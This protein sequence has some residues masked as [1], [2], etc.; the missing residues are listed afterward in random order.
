MQIKK[1]P[2]II[3]RL[4]EVAPPLKEF[5][6]TLESCP[7]D[8]LII[9]IREFGSLP[10][11]RP[12]G[13]LCAWIP[14]LNRFDLI[15]EEFVTKY[16]LNTDFPRPVEI[17]KEDE[18]VLVNVLQFSSFLLEKCSNRGIYASIKHLSHLI[19]ATSPSIVAAALRVSVQLAHRFA[20]S[21][22]GK[23][24]VTALDPEKIF[25][26]ATLLP[27][28]HWE[29][30][31]KRDIAYVDYI[32]KNSEH[33]WD[34]DEWLTFSIQY[35]VRSGENKGK[36]GSPNAN[37]SGSGVTGSAN[38]A[39]HSRATNSSFQ[40][41]TPTRSLSHRQPDALGLSSSASPSLVPVS[42]PSQTSSAG[43]ASA[44]MP[45]SSEATEGLATLH[46][47]AE[48]IRNLSFVQLL[49]KLY[50]ALPQES[51]F[52]A[53]CKA[54][55]AKAC[56]NPM[57]AESIELRRE[58]CKIQFSA[59]SF[60]CCT[61]SEATVDSRIITKAPNLIRQIASIISPENSS[62]VDTEFS[63]LALEALEFVCHQ[64]ARRSD[65]LAALS[66]N[67]SH[68]VLMTVVRNIIRDL[69]N[70]EQHTF[71][72]EFACR[73]F[74]L[75]LQLAFTQS[76][77]AILVTTGLVQL[78]LEV[79]V[80]QTPYVRTLGAAMELLDQV[81][82]DISS[83]FSTFSQSGGI[84]ILIEVIKREISCD[85]SPDRPKEKIPDYCT[86]DYTLSFYRSQWVRS[87]FVV[88]SN[89]LVH[90]RTSENIHNLVDSP[91]LEASK[92]VI[93]NPTI[94]G[95]RI[96]SLNLQ[97][98]SSML[99]NE[100]SSFG[101]M[102]EAK[103]VDSVLNQVPILLEKSF[104]YFSPIAKLIGALSHNENGIKIIQERNMIAKFMESLSNSLTTN[105]TLPLLGAVFEGLTSDHPELRKQ[106]IS[107]SKVLLRDLPKLLEPVSDPSKF[108]LE[109]E[110]SNVTNH[111]SQ[112]EAESHNSMGDS[113]ADIDIDIDAN[114][115]AEQPT[116]T[117][118]SI[119]PETP[120]VVVIVG[121][122]ASFFDGL[123]KNH[124]TRVQFIKQNGVTDLLKIF[125]IPNLPYDFA[126]SSVGYT[127]GRI[128]RALF[129]L[130]I[131]S[132]AI[133]REI[134]ERIE[135]SLTEVEEKIRETTLESQI[136]RDDV[137]LDGIQ[138]SLAILNGLLQA[139]FQ[140]V[141]YDYGTGYRVMFVL[142]KIVEG[143]CEE[144][145]ITRLA[146]VQRWCIWQESRSLDGL[147]NLFIEATRPLSVDITRNETDDYKKIKEAEAKLEDSVS[148]FFTHV[149][150]FRFVANANSIMT[151]KIFSE[152]AAIC[153]NE[154][155]ISSR[156]KNGLKMADLLADGMVGLLE[157][158][159]LAYGFASDDI[160]QQAKL[161]TLIST[162]AV[163]QRVMF[164]SWNSTLA[165]YLGVFVMFKQQG[166]LQKLLDL[167][168][169][170][171]QL[172]VQG[173]GSSDG[174]ES[175]SSLLL[176]AQK[177]IL[178]FLGYT[179][180]HR[181]L[182]ENARLVS[183]LSSRDNSYKNKEF[184]NPKQFFVE[185]RIIVLY[186]LQPLWDSENLD[187]KDFQI[188]QLFLDIMTK[189]FS[190]TGED[191]SDKGPRDKLPRDLSWKFIC[192]SEYK[193]DALVE[194]G[195]PEAAARSV[196]KEHNDNISEAYTTLIERTDVIPSVSL[197]EISVNDPGN[198]GSSAP[199]TETGKRLVLLADLNELRDSIKSK[200]IDRTLNLI[201]SHPKNVYAASQLII[202]AHS[203]FPGMRSEREK[204][205]LAA[206][207][208]DIVTTILQAL[209]SCDVDSETHDQQ[210]AAVSHFLGIILKDS[211]FF[212]SCFE[213]LVESI[214][215]FVSLLASSNAHEKDWYPSVLLI[216]ER[217]VTNVS[218]PNPEQATFDESSLSSSF[219][220]FKTVLPKIPK[221]T[222][223]RI[224]KILS[225]PMSF[226]SDACALAIA[227]LYVHF[228]KDP[229]SAAIL[230]SGALE[231][232]LRSVKQFGDSSN[233]EKLETAIL[234]VLRQ[235]VETKDS[236]KKL[237][238]K[239]IRAWFMTQRLADAT[240]FI[241][242]NS[243]LV[244]RSPEIFVEVASDLLTVQDTSL[245]TT[246]VCLKEYL[247]KRR[248]K[249]LQ[250]PKRLSVDGSE[251]IVPKET[252]SAESEPIKEET[253]IQKEDVTMLGNDTAGQSKAP[254]LTY[255]SGV[256]NLI[257]SEL[258][259]LN[260]EEVY[261]LPT[262]TEAALQEYMAKNKTETP[263][264][265]SEHRPF[266]YF[267]FLFKVLVELLGSYNQC[268]LEFLNFSAKS[269]F[270]A[271]VFGSNIQTK[272]K[273]Y[274]LLHFV[275]EYLSVGIVN[276]A[277]NSTPIKEWTSISTLASSAI[278]SLMTSTGESD[279]GATNEE[280]Q[281]DSVILFVRKFTL[282][283]IA[284]TLKDV[285]A[286]YSS[287]DMKYSLL[288]SLSELCHRLLSNR[289]G[290]SSAEPSNDIADGAAIAKIMYDKKF[291]S[292]FSVN[293]GMV[294]LNYPHV[295]KVVKQDL[296]FLH[297]L[298][299]L[300]LDISDQLG[301]E[302]GQDVN[303]DDDVY[304][305]S[306]LDIREDTPDLFRNSTLGMFEVGDPMYDDSEELEEDEV[307]QSQD[308]DEMDYDD[309]NDEVISDVDEDGSDENESIDFE[310]DE[311]DDEAESDESD[312]EADV[313]DDGMGVSY[314][315]VGTR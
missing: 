154:R 293:V 251:T 16:E 163:L 231:N 110:P 127:L 295:K 93:S 83:T 22:A 187:S 208:K 158:A 13:D 145:F 288:S 259:K 7:L 118:A 2:H 248:K 88:V 224:F 87:L 192:P 241:R 239:E 222:E 148:K 101:I 44:V 55:V 60:A 256:I 128:L 97:I 80:I 177:V 49:E 220:I 285:H 302:E 27:T 67:V 152:F 290:F 266:I 129:T 143:K 194:I 244:C 20:Q 82:I 180:S 39:G 246:H 30:P 21:R 91:L 296:R 133:Q 280:I 235:C 281:N 184:F 156:K 182:L 138:R 190:F 166:G 5:V 315:V 257:L 32:T 38:T 245:S 203:A 14:V 183:P 119:A 225:T 65:V 59:L 258:F 238:T 189:L 210:I 24:N 202:K 136:V 58:L 227:R 111:R 252:D 307:V 247:I 15:L 54:R 234:I 51:W 135:R 270:P 282:D 196:L 124:L 116:T 287:L 4:A 277:Q 11:D 120:E 198:I 130:D 260:P 250:L 98:L 209:S 131:D 151:S 46:V 84:G 304:D 213:D 168:R 268:K 72:E 174:V 181:S 3:K 23:G 109:S 186:S 146:R 214:D 9:K 69:Q 6:E 233:L 77:G 139:F 175:T 153:T 137:H 274:T 283:V 81:I 117:E 300:A 132:D 17:S 193:V 221:E 253:E 306:E 41:H 74:R 76:L 298:S 223:E 108:Y 45:S 161:H 219:D 71:N 188:S 36:D 157:F 278:L 261:T 226:K 172:N 61:F 206:V 176:F 53:A 92:Q 314:S 100:P 170:L 64:P 218:V 255:S 121:Y 229:N 126:F 211:S 291:A 310:D 271:P 155:A 102:H 286:T 242:A 12:R 34:G 262:R 142:D 57:S 303:L 273:P 236:I 26:L 33:Y 301:G 42:T 134:I 66:A 75:I 178:M 95:S 185:C 1:T 289:P 105:E 275:F 160:Y 107:E 112:N 147:S 232:L 207:H 29:T 106:V 312:I 237:M 269:Q 311:D 113:N 40:P 48:D 90:T 212:Q 313:D 104:S 197:E 299:R 103:L 191:G 8:D 267:Y 159:P 70:D 171:W 68:G 179:I 123:L 62:V 85:L 164:K 31:D 309:V 276:P 99:E 86:V 254:Q 284:K 50:S 162:L 125:E 292:L 200:L 73:I 272:P 305:D 201:Q 144:N 216:L 47:S 173:N 122:V 217:I 169:A 265:S 19:N 167:L 205:A 79:I 228:S 18:Y 94:F 149:K 279:Y 37:S 199:T 89:I 141:F 96:V 240:V 243:H 140:M 25:K 43:A 63:I 294:D 195:F 78:L 150:A 35:Y 28:S 115:Q 165:A 204:E 10:W 56:T 249:S 114:G 297:K 308:S 215:I 230:K 52:M 264:K 263:F